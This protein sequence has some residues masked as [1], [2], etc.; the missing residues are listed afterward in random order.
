[1]PQFQ[2]ILNYTRPVQL[3]FALLT[4][5]L[6]LGIARY[7]G[8]SLLL[9]P[10]FIGG[11]ILVLIMATSG[12]MT[13]Y[14][15]PF[16]ESIIQDE[17]RKEREELRSQLLVVSISFLVTVAVLV[18]LLGRDGFLHA[19]AAII[20]GLFTLLALGNA[21][22]PLRLANR[23]LGELSTSIQIA[24]LSPALA[25]LLQFGS[26]NRIITIYTFPLLLLALT[27]F[28]SLNFPAYAEDLKYERKSLLL[29]LT[30]QRAVPIHNALLVGSFLFFAIIPFLGVPFQLVW[31]ALLTLPLAAYQVFALR[32]LAD[33][34][35]PIWTIFVT[36]A[37]AIFGLTTYLIALTFWLR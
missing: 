12:L 30:W 37:T 11:M 4:Y 33:G 31:P 6:G 1:M 34:A 17:T 16:N 14:F 3:I 36:T 2:R 5:G 35:K 15:R 25:F 19:G 13:E 8:A 32:N 21:I 18:F 20:L 9:E 10:Q 29:S 24:S 7:L 23:G 22:P 26:L 28:L 27:Y